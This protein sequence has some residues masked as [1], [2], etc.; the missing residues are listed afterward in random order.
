[1]C[2]GH[3]CEA[4]RSCEVLNSSTINSYQN[5]VCATECKKGATAS[6][7]A[8]RGLNVHVAKL[9]RD[10]QPVV[11]HESS[12]GGFDA[13]LAVG[14][15]RDVGGAGVPAVERPLGLSVTD[16]E[17]AGRHCERTQ[18]IGSSV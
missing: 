4:I 12:A 8:R 18:V 15:Q 3:A 6:M 9:A 13:L 11:S 2:A 14:R 7:I 17:D 16:D 1:M 10:N 5:G